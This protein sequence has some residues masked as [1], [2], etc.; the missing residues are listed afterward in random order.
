MHT[1]P[2]IMNSEKYLTIIAEEVGIPRDELQAD[3]EFADLGMNHRLAQAIT[4]RFAEETS[5]RLPDLIFTEYPDVQSFVKYL[6]QAQ[7]QPVIQ[8]GAVQVKGKGKDKKPPLVLPLQGNPATAKKTIFLLPDGSGS[9]MAYARLPRLGTDFCLCG[10]NSPFLGVGSFITTIEK[11]ATIF[12]SAIREVQPHGPY[13]LGGWSAGG[14]FSTEIARLMLRAGELVEAIVL[15]DSPCRVGFESLPMDVVRYLAPRN[16]MGNW[17]DKGTPV[18]LVDH[19]QG[20]LAAVDV[21]TPSRVEGRVP[22]VFCIE[23]SD[24]VLES[25]AELHGT[26][27]DPNIK[28][29]RHMLGPRTR[30]FNPN[31]WDRVFPSSQLR[32]ARSSG[33]HFTMVHPP[34]VSKLRCSL[35]SKLS[36]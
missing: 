30:Q 25:I 31:G 27:L 29:T 15:I 17:G 18:W 13:I 23:A 28:L 11:F 16:L 12:M 10:V 34:N 26:G 7:G 2:T 33:S 24:G 4:D 35:P 21:Y 19:F 5:N 14:Y 8:R 1:S 6:G 22:F 9:G 3:T 32:W 20:T 36:M